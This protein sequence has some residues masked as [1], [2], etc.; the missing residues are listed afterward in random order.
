MEN[1][2]VEAASKDLSYPIGK[3]DPGVEVTRELRK[4]FI[5][6]IADLPE[7]ISQ[8]VEGL[9]EEQIDTPYRPEGWTVRQTVHHVADSHINSL[10]R[11]KLAMTEENPTIRP[12]FEDRW[13]DL[14]DSRLPVD[15]SLKLLEAVHRRWIALLDAMTDED[16]QKTLVHPDSGEWTIEKFLALYAWHSRHHTAHITKLRDRNGW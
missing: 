10:C 11:F 9:S 14:A 3:F 4:E 12:Y 5:Q 15:V 16:F 13:A 2:T 7:R 1:T 6:T 8:A